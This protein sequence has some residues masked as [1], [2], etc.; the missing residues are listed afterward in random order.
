[1]PFNWQDQPEAAGPMTEPRYDPGDGR[2]ALDIQAMAQHSVRLPQLDQD[3]LAAGEYVPVSRTEAPLSP[4]QR[5]RERH[6][7]ALSYDAGRDALRATFENAARHAGADPRVARR[8][9][10]ELMKQVPETSQDQS[11]HSHLGPE[12]ETSEDQND[13]GRLDAGQA[14]E[15]EQRGLDDSPTPTEPGPPVTTAAEPAA[16]RPRK[17]E[18]S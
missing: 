15:P 16:V 10:D 1:M 4:E 7:A 12:P 5:E 14:A 17:Q 9:A 3:A 11:D 2:P 18:K 13:D 6:Q 8:T